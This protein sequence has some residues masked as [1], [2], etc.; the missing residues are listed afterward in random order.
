MR[1]RSLGLLL[2]ASAWLAGVAAA[3]PPPGRL[4]TGVVRAL[5]HSLPSEGLAVAIALAGDALP[6]G[7]GRAA[8]I[9]AAQQRVIGALPPGSFRTKR[10]Y[11]HV[12]GLAGWAQREA[13][14]A[15]AAQ[16]DVALVYLD[17]RVSRVLAQ[18]VPLVGG[19]SAHTQGYT[20]A[21]IT[22]AVIDSGIDA[23]H[24]D[25]V[26][27][28]VAQQCFCNDKPSPSRGCCPNGRATQ[29]GPGAAAETD[30][31]GTSVAGIITSRGLVAAP[32]IAPDEIGRAH[33]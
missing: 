7:R 24:P 8:A 31:H 20:G 22:A 32:R 10:R 1:V 11:K 15:L 23:A 33:V 2:A 4:E 27:D 21:G 18:G 3:D 9:H 26:D 12:A 14:E 16:P 25:L 30:G 29:S 17:G 19:T 6:G 28:V 13:L 5:D